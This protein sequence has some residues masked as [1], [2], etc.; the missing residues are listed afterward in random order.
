MT[1]GK[2]ASKNSNQTDDCNQNAESRC[3]TN[4][5]RP[6]QC[7]TT[8]EELREVKL[9]TVTCPVVLACLPSLEKTC[10]T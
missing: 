3:S 9:L 6:N 4:A 10:Q 7:D 1:Y 8:V 2:G 5:A